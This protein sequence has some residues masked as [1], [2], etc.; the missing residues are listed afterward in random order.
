MQCQLFWCVNDSNF[1]A[2]G[3]KIG[4]IDTPGFGDSRGMDEDKEHAQQIIAALKEVEHVNSSPDEYGTPSV[5]KVYS[6]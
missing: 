6:A 5:T 4:I 1:E 3:L 2:S